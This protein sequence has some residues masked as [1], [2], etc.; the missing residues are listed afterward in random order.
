MA[1]SAFTAVST[2]GRLGTSAST[3]TSIPSQPQQA[4]PTQKIEWPPAVRAYVQRSFAAENEASGVSKE[5]LTARM[6]EVINGSVTDHTLHT[7]DWDSYP[8]PQQLI[9]NDL[10][11]K[12]AAP[13]PQAWQNIADIRMSDSSAKTNVPKPK[14]RK[15]SEP[16][17]N[18]SAPMPPW[19]SSTASSNGFESRLTYPEP[20]MSKRE[21]KR[22]RKFQEDTGAL[23]AT[24]KSNEYLEKRRQR[25]EKDAPR[26]REITPPLDAVTG[27]IVGTC[28]KLEKRYLRLTAP[29]KPDT[30]RP[31]HIL[32]QTYELLRSKWKQDHD[33][34]Y[35]CDQFK[36]LRQDL[37]V[38]HL[39][40]DFL[41]KVYETHAR[42]ALEVG[43]VGEYNQCQT[44]LRALYKQDLGGHPAEFLAYR[45]L[46]FVYTCNRVDMNRVL[47]DV[48][49]A[50]KEQPAVK[51][52]LEARSALALSNYHRFFK[53][54]NET[55]NMGGYLMDMFVDRERLV[56]LASLCR[57]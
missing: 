27:P 11:G 4:P 35:I 39:R 15:S 36:S 48:T 49:P 18:V 42:I 23:P 31:L 9:L 47:S 53:L 34:N 14:K 6:K 55:P 8:L 21:E 30:V 54:Y 45:V 52:A 51:H 13:P 50:D 28:E 26:Q 3:K 17:E 12:T 22:R 56:A 44:Q 7:R 20:E 24:S 37:T 40:N 57:G 29:P 25:F 38:Q 43:D 32:R 41:V 5:Q 19:R 1:A 16:D 46:Y 2:R 33:Y 10:S